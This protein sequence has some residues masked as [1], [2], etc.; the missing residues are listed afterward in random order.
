MSCHQN[1]VNYT[2]S[3]RLEQIWLCY[4]VDLLCLYG[5]YHATVR[6]THNLIYKFAQVVHPAS[7]WWLNSTFRNWQVLNHW[8]FVGC[9]D[10]II[11]IIYC[12]QAP[13]K[14]HKKHTAAV[15]V[16]FLRMSPGLGLLTT[17]WPVKS[18]SNRRLRLQ[19]ARSQSAAFHVGLAEGITERVE[20]LNKTHDASFEAIFFALNGMGC[21]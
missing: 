9:L 11:Y 4:F 5:I 21:K 10:R 12:I 16:W 3:S 13:S 7:S 18:R 15:C 2:R 20:E 17:L 6:R 8:G 19:Q 14:Q 1:D